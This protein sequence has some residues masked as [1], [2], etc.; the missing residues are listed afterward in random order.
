MEMRAGKHGRRA[1]PCPAL[2]SPKLCPS[3]PA[4]P[5]SP[6]GPPD[7]PS[8]SPGQV[9]LPR[10]AAAPFFFGYK[11]KS[12][13][14]LPVNFNKKGVKGNVYT[15]LIKEGSCTLGGD[16]IISHEILIQEVSELLRLITPA[17]SEGLCLYTCL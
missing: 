4:T 1:C 3:Q 8:C 6:Q 2:P 5:E 16:R 11:G 14:L 7:E 10:K 13:Q 12:C 9:P 17:A 15:S